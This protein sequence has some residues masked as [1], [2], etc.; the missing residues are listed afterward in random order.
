[1]KNIDILVDNATCLRGDNLIFD[2][3]SF[4]LSN[5]EILFIMGP[6]GCGK[7]TLIRSLCGIQHLENGCIKI[8]NVN[9]N[10]PECNF[11]ENLVY[12][13]HNDSLSENLTTYENLEYLNKFDLSNKDE[14]ISNP[15]KFLKF[16]DI[17]KYKNYLVSELSQG[18]KK[19][20]ALSRLLFTNKKIWVLDE[21]LSFLDEDSKNNLIKLFLDHI[22]NGG[23]IVTSTHIDFSNYFEKS[24]YLNM[25]G[26]NINE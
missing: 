23:L 7:T 20:V 1:L 2:N 11:L 10:N 9:I 17:S 18:N 21:P 16:F 22:T 4:N 14:F 6:N 24:K 19:K 25:K 26:I 8:N 5:G 3:I 12:I 15:N 13:G